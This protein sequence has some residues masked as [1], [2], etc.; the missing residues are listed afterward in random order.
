M[1]NTHQDIKIAIIGGGAM[2]SALAKGLLLKHEITPKNICIAD[3][4]TSHLEDL[5]EKGIKITGSNKEA[6]READLIIIAVKPWIV[7][8]VLSEIELSDFPRN[9]EWCFIVAG[10]PSQD[11]LKMFKKELPS[12]LSIA[13]PNTAMSVS[14][15]M[16]FVVPVRGNAS[17]AKSVFNQVG[18][19]MEIEERLLPGSMALVSCGIAF[20]FRYIRA[21][22]EGGVELG[23]KASEAQKMVT[24]TLK[25]AVTL[26]ENNN[27]HPE[28][29]IDKVTTPGGI[30]I[31]G[32][33]A[34]EKFGFTTSVIE[35]LKACKP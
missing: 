7:N 1:A 16:T 9:A 27:S 29:E 21:A 3:P 33:N 17:L 10:I 20:A 26:L 4:F 6:I 15:S 23:I 5:K 18:K 19:V 35:G 14:E 31:K 25:G 24:Q 22:S 32:L 8:T 34:M 13:I 2:G 28:A 30:T 11:L 12:S